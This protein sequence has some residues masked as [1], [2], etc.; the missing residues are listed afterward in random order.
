MDK[1][2][3]SKKYLDQFTT[4]CQSVLWKIYIKYYNNETKINEEK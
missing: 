1:K 3:I 4:T 2:K